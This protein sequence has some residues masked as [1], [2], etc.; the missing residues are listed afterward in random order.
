MQGVVISAFIFNVVVC[1][2][3][4]FP[5][6]KLHSLS[7]MDDLHASASRNLGPAPEGQPDADQPEIDQKAWRETTDG[8]ESKTGQLYRLGRQ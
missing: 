8:P 6:G 2:I 7:R 4:M 1:A 5:K 3:V